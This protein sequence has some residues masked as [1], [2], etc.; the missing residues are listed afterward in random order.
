MSHAPRVFV[1]PDPLVDVVEAV[2]SSGCQVIESLDTADAVVW[3]GRDPAALADLLPDTVRWLQIP[4]AG[5][6]RWLAGGLVGGSFEVTSARGVYA[7]QIAEH[8]LALILACARR[9]SVFV[10]ADDWQPQAAAVMSLAGCEVLI[11]G[12][13]GIGTALI[14]MLTP[15]GCRTV[16]VTRSGREVAGASVSSSAAD[17]DALLP[18]ADVVVIAA[19]ATAETA[20]LFNA[21]R[22]DRMKPTAI[23]VNVA[24]GSLIDTDA[25][26]A[27][28]DRG[29]LCAVGLDVTDPEPLPAGHPLFTH[30]RVVLTPHVANPPELKREAFARHVAANCARFKAG[31]P[32][33]AIVDEGRGY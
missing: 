21:E 26:L 12:A 32:L 20:Q 15:L 8:A 28:L 13:G 22:L 25:L 17:L 5:A 4:D 16:A 29:H 11:V 9:L 1:G 7:P 33:L 30:A 27:V 10:R 31:L 23:L 24:R 14:A 2:R 18:S 6:E 3:F 19:P